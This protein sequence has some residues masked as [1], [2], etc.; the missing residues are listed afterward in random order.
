MIPMN[1]IRMQARQV[2]KVSSWG[3][4]SKHV[5]FVFMVLIT[6]PGMS[7]AAEASSETS[8]ETSP[9]IASETLS[10]YWTFGIRNVDVSGSKE[11]YRQHVNLDNG[12]WLSAFGLV[13]KPQ[14]KTAFT[15]DRIEIMA[16]NLGSE[17][18]Q[19]F[20]IGVRKYG[21]YRFSYARQKSEYFYQDIMLD[22]VDEDPY[23][24]NGGDYHHF[25][26][27]RV[28]DQLDFNVQLN[29]NAKLF[30][31]LDQYTKQGDSTTVFGIDREEFELE[32]PVDQKLKNYN[33]GFEY[34]WKQSAVTFN[35]RWRD[36]NNEVEVFLLDPSEG[37]DSTAPTQLDNFFLQQPYG[38]DSSETQ[39]NFISRPTD[40]LT[41]QANVLYADLDMDLD[42]TETA[43]GINFM[44]EVLHYNHSAEGQS[45]RTIHQLYLSSAY[46]FTDY[47]KFIASIRDQDL[48][49]NS[50][51]NLAGVSSENQW[52][53]DS[54][55]FAIGVE[56]IISNNWT[57]TGG[58]TIESRETTYDPSFVS[59]GLYANEESKN[60]GYYLMLAYRP[61]NGLILT[62]S[63]E[64]NITEDPYT[65][66]SPTD[67]QHLR[68]SAVYKWN[69]GFK[70][71]SAY[72]W[73]NIKNEHSGWQANSKQTN[74][75]LSYFNDPFTIS[76]GTSI[77]DLDRSIDQLVTGGFV[78][79][80]FPINYRADADFWDGLIQWKINSIANLMASYRN[81]DN[82]GNFAVKR[83]DA[84]FGINFE[85]PRNYSLGANYRNIDYQEDFEDFDA[86]ILEITFGG[87]W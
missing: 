53:I 13:I 42:S 34:R 83:K 80:L 33:I 59:S 49:Q 44:G 19:N 5:L 62:A 41:L 24:S 29:D 38:Y 40:S 47:I 23:M 76:F 63:A 57:L 87:R 7:S 82:K 84:R 78:Q 64:N 28:R 67:S 30:L 2:S 52:N 50:E 85:L 9:E 46:V 3:E 15:P 22:P 20:R 65:L 58:L 71:S 39:L 11:K 1:L 66:S 79:V 56:T 36:F 73:R 68:L 75:R 45:M 26:F 32:Q 74:L 69:S 6:I 72:V 81:Y 77:V 54:T 51:L 35:Q 37:S 70:F 17:P 60:D 61:Q 31:K 4:S 14:E 21:S 86:K 55:T 16:A 8:S 18:Y 10:G 43:T 27:D 25:D 12:M 48:E